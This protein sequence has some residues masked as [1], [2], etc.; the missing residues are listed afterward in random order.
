MIPAGAITLYHPTE[1]MLMDICQYIHGLS[2][3]Y[4]IDN[5]LQKNESLLMKIRCL[6]NVIYIDNDGNKGVA[7]ALNQAVRMCRE[8]HIPWLLLLEQ[9]SSISISSIQL[10]YQYATDYPGHDLGIV[11]ANY[12]P[13]VKSSGIDEPL[14]VITSG[15]LINVDICNEIGGFLD[16]LFIDEVD[17]EYCLRLISH[18]YR[19][20]KLNYIPF[21]H[22]L[23]NKQYDRKIITYNYPPA[24]YYYII[25]NTLYVSTKYKK[26]FPLLHKHKLR[27]IKKWVKM[28]FYEPDTITKLIFMVRGAIDYKRNRLGTYSWG[29]EK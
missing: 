20:L 3:C 12:K 5:S 7:Y 29:T 27:C 21:K 18:G 14:E 13:Q 28:I 24:R 17:N 2:P 22:N 1:S 4:I 15:S 26:L 6:P 10:M 8:S 25:R 9:D 19:I 23:G 11:A 16:E